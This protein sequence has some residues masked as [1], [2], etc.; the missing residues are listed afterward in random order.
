MPFLAYRGLPMSIIHARE[1]GRQ[2]VLTEDRSTFLYWE[3]VLDVDC[4]YNPGATAYSIGGGGNVTITQTVNG[5]NVNLPVAPTNATNT[6][7]QAPTPTPG[8][9]PVYT[10]AALRHYLAMPRGQLVY[11]FESPTPNQP[12]I[13][14]L[15]TPWGGYNSDASNGPTVERCDV[16]QCWGSRTFLVSVRIVARV[17]EAAQTVTVGGVANSGFPVLLSNRYR[18]FV[19]QDTDY[20]ATVTTEGKATFRVDELQQRGVLPDQFLS[21]LAPPL[22]AGFRRESV[23]RQAL[24]DGAVY[25]YRVVDRE[26]PMNVPAAVGQQQGVTRVEALES[27]NMVEPNIWGGAGGFSSLLGGAHAIASGTGLLAR[28]GN[29]PTMTRAGAYVTAAIAVGS[30]FTSTFPVLTE[31]VLVRVWGN[32]NRVRRRLQNYAMAI[33][34]TRIGPPRAGHNTVAGITHEITG[35]FVELKMSHTAKAAALFG[36]LLAAGQNFGTPLE[37]M[38]NS[39]VGEETVAAQGGEQRVPGKLLS[40]QITSNAAPPNSSGARGTWG[41]NIQ[42]APLTNFG[43]LPPGG[44]VPRNNVDQSPPF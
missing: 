8:V 13:V 31:E 43:G 30:F 39:F 10:D 15:R 5:R 26:L 2:A 35:K 12:P 7:G 33:A 37:W 24:E 41:G 16:L 32:S 1:I 6:L 3:W 38:E 20:F 4:V 36:N 9:F 22:Q 19:D 27:R 18:Q 11:G 28:G 25:L 29:A 17:N 14:L 23:Q 21:Y 40:D 42:A 44:P 34:L